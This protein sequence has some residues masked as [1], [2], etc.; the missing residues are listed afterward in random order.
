MDFNLSVC[1]SVISVNIWFYF[2]KCLVWFFY[3]S[4]NIDN[5]VQV[6]LNADFMHTCLFIVR[7][8]HVRMKVKIMVLP[9]ESL[10]SFPVADHRLRLTVP[11]LFTTC[12]M[13]GLQWNQTVLMWSTPLPHWL[14]GAFDSWWCYANYANFAF[15]VWFYVVVFLLLIGTS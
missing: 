1:M 9:F 10:V 3:N 6:F 13:D 15:A 12:M 5:S 8:N 14:V 2:P 11:Y 7:V 4:L